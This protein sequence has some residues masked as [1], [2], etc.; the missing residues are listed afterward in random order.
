MTLGRNYS[1]PTSKQLNK[2]DWSLNDR[3]NE[4]LIREEPPD[5]EI[6]TDIS[7]ELD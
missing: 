3:M 2:F 5:E 6:P 7:T 1:L 4:S